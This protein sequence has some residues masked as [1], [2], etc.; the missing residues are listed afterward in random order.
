VLPLIRWVRII[1]P[2]LLSP[3]AALATDLCAV[4]MDYA[5]LPLPSASVNVTNLTT[6]KS[7]AVRSGKDGTACLSGIPEGLYSVE[8]SLTG[9]LHVKYYPVRTVALAKQTLS[10]LLP[11]AE[12]TEGG[13]GQES[14]LVGTL[15]KGGVPVGSA[16]VCMIGVTAAPRTCTVTDELGE[17]ALL[18]PAGVYITEIRTRDGQLYKSKVD[19]SSPGVYR[20]RLSLDAS[21]DKH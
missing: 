17:Y 4:V 2:I 6:G 19:L 15:L 20:N 14:T 12:V 3:T 5:R 11:F 1:A 21:A 8:A 16:E 9:F 10:F 18:G 13:L 7:Y